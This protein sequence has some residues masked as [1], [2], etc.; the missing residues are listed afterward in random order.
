MSGLKSV[1]APVIEISS[2]AL[3]KAAGVGCWAWANGLKV[4]RLRP[5]AAHRAALL[6]AFATLILK[7][8][9]ARDS[10]LFDHPHTLRAANNGRS[11]ETYKETVFNHPRP[12]RKRMRQSR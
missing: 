11:C 8:H 12:A 9:L 1:V 7:L 2:L 5:R 4:T 6:M 3:A 10:R